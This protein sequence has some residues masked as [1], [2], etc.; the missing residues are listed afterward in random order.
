MAWRRDRYQNHDGRWAFR[1]IFQWSMNQI[2]SFSFTHEQLK[3]S[4]AKYRSFCPGVNELKAEPLA[5]CCKPRP[6]DRL[7][8]HGIRSITELDHLKCGPRPGANLISYEYRADQGRSRGYF[9]VNQQRPHWDALHIQR[10]SR[11]RDGVRLRCKIFRL[12]GNGGHNADD[13]FKYIVLNDSYC[14]LFLE[15]R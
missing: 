6:I 10:K 1:T 8:A 13:V 9:L 4:S 14:I 5:F 3:I 15:F 11:K 2:T 7:R 12:R